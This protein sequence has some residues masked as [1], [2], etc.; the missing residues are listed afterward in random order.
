MAEKL[1]GTDG[2]RGIVGEILTNELAYK[3]GR[4]IPHLYDSSVD[5]IKIVVGCDTRVSSHML[6]CSLVAGLMESG[7]DVITLDIMPSAGVAYLAKT[8]KAN[9]GIMITAS[10]NPYYYNG[11]KIFNGNGFK[12]TKNQEQ[13]IEQLVFDNNFSNL[14][15]E[16]IGQKTECNKATQC[17][18]NYL[19][20]NASGFFDNLSIV[21]D[22]ANGAGVK[23][24]PWVLKK[25]GVKVKVLA[26][27]KNG[28][29]INEKCGATH[30][31]L[32]C[33][34]VKKGGFNLGF[35]LDGDAD[36][37]MI[38][39]EKGEVVEGEKILFL[40]SKYLKEKKL[41]KSNIIVSTVM[42]NLSLEKEL[43]K[44]GI[45]LITTAVGDEN[46]V[47]SMLQN[48]LN[49]G[50]E[51]SGHYMFQNAVTTS[52][53]ILSAIIFLNLLKHYKQPV[54]KLCKNF[55]LY[56][57]KLINFEVKEHQKEQILNNKLLK[58]KVQGWEKALNSS[59]RI[60]LRASGTESKVRLLV[61]A[62]D[63][64][65]LEQIIVNLETT[66]KSLLK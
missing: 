29:K 18:E 40:F 16:K 34:E 65:L 9:A 44:I 52:D 66:I 23:V 38:V 59:G 1:F 41:L 48:N 31:E 46:V 53:G 12:L 64:K 57:Q 11:I 19:V 37:L 15:Q 7:A 63:E 5:K 54:S 22:C 20:S 28:L 2:I 35:A 47:T 39:D 62:K 3:V 49:F 26:N 42:S 58:E 4:A 50:G 43:K 33:N 14:P 27:S 13:Q 51:T 32:L 21:V 36:R 45:S 17:Y 30:L 25:L 8:L 61:E 55:L 24:F 6:E 60:L 56:A 10:H